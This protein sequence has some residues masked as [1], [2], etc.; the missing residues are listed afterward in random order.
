MVGHSKLLSEAGSQDPGHVCH[1]L[2]EA[3]YLSAHGCLLDMKNGYAKVDE[4]RLHYVAGQ[5]IK[6]M[7][8]RFRSCNPLNVSG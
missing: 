3:A 6:A 2:K 8:V 5:V 4:T 7:T 1:R